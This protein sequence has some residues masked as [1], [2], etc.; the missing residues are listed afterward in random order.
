[1][2]LTYKIKK[3][4]LLLMKWDFIKCLFIHRVAAGVEHMPILC[5]QPYGTI[6]DVGANRGQFSLA[7]SVYCHD[8]QILAFEPLAQ[9]ASRFSD[10]F[11]SNNKVHLFIK[12]LGKSE[13]SASKLYISAKDH[14]SSLLPISELLPSTFPGTH[15]VGTISVEVSTLDSCLKKYPISK[16]ALLKI[17]V[18]GTELDVLRGATGILDKFKYIYIELSFVEFY[19]DQKLAN[20]LI[21]WLLNRG[22]QL[23]A[24][25]NLIY[26]KHGWPLQGDFMF[27]M[28]RN[29]NE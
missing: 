12:A 23:T 25:F 5:F 11:K 10:I 29:S 14:S 1:M 3:F 20:E 18:Q 9:A 22:Y 15:S 28:S 21:R 17:D 7:A 13:S 16:P 8:A 24:V 4:A 27:T 6:V 26:D 2:R 19:K